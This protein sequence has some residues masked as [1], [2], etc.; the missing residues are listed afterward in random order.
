MNQIGYL[1][2]RS[3]SYYKDDIAVIDHGNGVEYSFRTVNEYSNALARRLSKL[4]LEKGDRIAIMCF[5]SIEFIVSDFALAK[6]G[7]VRV[8]INPFLAKAEVEYIIRDSGARCVIFDHQ[9][10]SIISDIQRE[11]K[12]SLPFLISN[13]TNE[14]E[15]IVYSLKEILKNESGES[16]LVE[17][18]N[19]DIYQI[20]YTSGT[21]GKPKGAIISYKS[22]LITIN[23]VLADELH[24]KSGDRMLHMA[25]LSHGSGSK[26]LPHFVKGATNVLCR[27]FSPELFFQVVEKYKVTTTFLV[28]TMIGMLLDYEDRTKYDF[29]SL[30]TVLYAASPIPKEMLKRA[31]D[32]FGPILVQVYA[33][34]EAPNPVLVLS[35]IDHER[36]ANSGKI[37]ESAGREVTN[38][39]VDIFD[40][41]DNP[42]NVNEIGEVVISGEHIMSGYWNNTLATSETIKKGWLYTGDL[43]YRDEKGYVFI[44]GRK[45]DM[46]ISG[47]YNVYAREVE[48]IIYKIEGIHEVA[49]IGEPDHKWG[50][51]VVA[52]LVSNKVTS[53]EEIIN[54]CKK[55][56][57]SYKIPKNIYF[58]QTLPKNANGKIDK[59]KLKERH[60]INN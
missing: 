6:S 8:P 14:N 54:H 18:S 28:P 38:V 35:K 13:K 46:V 30:E 39:R 43:G 36:S 20:L 1:I 21:T 5:N 60:K 50:E 33:L 32:V 53:E 47:G 2:E 9:F 15:S 3:S 29:S 23:N 19:E 56:L 25:S 45:K 4:G 51:K 52:H 44:V 37:L 24:I 42:V 40:N 27:K 34:T 22:R 58:H 49:V 41:Q 11:K 48:D 31:L 12:E 59:N 17:T 7:L 55:Y 16:F 26:V 10:T 57:A